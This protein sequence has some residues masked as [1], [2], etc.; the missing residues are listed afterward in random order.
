MSTSKAG[1]KN[2]D[3]RIKLY[4]EVGKYFSPKGAFN[5]K[6]FRTSLRSSLSELGKSRPRQ[7]GISEMVSNWL[8][9]YLSDVIH[10]LN[11][12][13][14]PEAS[15]RLLTAAIEESADL[16]IKNVVISAEHL[17]RLLSIA[18]PGAFPRGDDE[19]IQPVDVKPS[20]KSRRCQK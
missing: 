1:D 12:K 5:E 16:G 14:M 10:Y 8:N 2:N 15:L 17:R 7:Q 20:M 4:A 11:E 13:K 19:K 6:A 3:F 18:S 9:S